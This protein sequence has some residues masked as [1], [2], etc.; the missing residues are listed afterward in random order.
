[1]EVNTALDSV[2]TLDSDSA[3]PIEMETILDGVLYEWKSFQDIEV[4]EKEKP[5]FYICFSL[6]THLGQE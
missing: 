5:F 3:A 6:T 2:E 4:I 1:M